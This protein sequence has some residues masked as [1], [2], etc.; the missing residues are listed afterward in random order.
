MKMTLWSDD[1]I[2][3]KHAEEDLVDF[4]LEARK[5]GWP[6][7]DKDE[8]QPQRPGFKERV[9]RDVS[10]LWEYRDSYTGFFNAP[11]QEIVRFDDNP[12]WSMSYN[13]GMLPG[14]QHDVSFAK[15]TFEFLKEALLRADQKNPFRG[16]ERHTDFKHFGGYYLYENKSDGDIRDFVG[17]EIIGFGNTGKM[18]QAPTVFRQHYMGGLI[19]HKVA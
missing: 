9:Y 1:A 6:A 13:G 12:I 8:K 4:I 17:T 2:V 10:R 15:K 18:S 14:Y 19:V 3:R 16:P 5:H 11:G 7:V